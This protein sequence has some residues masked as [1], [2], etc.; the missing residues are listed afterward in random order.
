[1]RGPTI[2]DKRGFPVIRRIIMLAMGGVTMAHS[3]ALTSN[4]IL[5]VVLSFI[6][7][8]LATVKLLSILEGAP[9]EDPTGD[10]VHELRMQ[11]CDS[12]A[13]RTAMEEDGG[14]NLVV[15]AHAPFRIVRVTTDFERQFGFARDLALDRTQGLIHGP[16]T[17]VAGW[18]SLFD[19]ALAGD[20]AQLVV[21]AYSSD[22]A[23]RRRHMRVRPVLEGGS[24]RYLE[25]TFSVLAHTEG[26][27]RIRGENDLTFSSD[28]TWM[29]QVR[30]RA[31]RS[32]NLYL[33][34]MFIGVLLQE[35]NGQNDGLEDLI[36][37]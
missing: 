33:A 18:L 2:M 23:V 28:E 16:E 1:M 12:V 36:T 15:V 8:I 5:A 22:G 21:N 9:D 4:M 13:F 25:M 32:G 34:D 10:P 3:K 17:D 19:S 27:V 30:S 11:K 26:R 14:C 20:S 37:S 24:V 6:I 31:S 29:V 7:D 35:H